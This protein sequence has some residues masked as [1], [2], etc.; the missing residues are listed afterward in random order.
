MKEW[1]KFLYGELKKTLLS[2]AEFWVRKNS[3]ND[4]TEMKKTWAILWTDLISRGI[5]VDLLDSADT[6]GV[7]RSLRRVTAKW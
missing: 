3:K 6:I 1:E 4:T 5:L 2:G 7:L